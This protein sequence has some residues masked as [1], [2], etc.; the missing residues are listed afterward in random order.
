MR[1][2]HVVP[3]L[4][5]RFGG[6]PVAVLEAARALRDLGWDC[7]VVA[8]DLAEPASWSGRRVVDADLPEGAREVDVRLCPARWPYRLAYSPALTRALD[9][10]APSVDVVHIHMLFQY[11]QFAAFRAARRAGVPYVVTPHG[12]LDPH[13]RRRSR[14]L[15]ALTDLLW[16]RRML[17]GAAALHFTTA[18][19]A[20]LVSDLGFRAPTVVAPNG[21]RWASFQR[22]PSGR[23]F[24]EWYLGGHDGP[25]VM[26]LGRLSHKKGLDILVRA[27]AR[28]A[29]E[30][31]DAVLALVGPDDEGLTPRL[32][33]LAASEGVADRIVFVGMLAGEE[34]RAALAAADVWA[35]PSHTENFGLAVVE[36]MAAG[37]AVV[38][39]PAVNLASEISAAG[40]GLVRPQTPDAFA[41]AL[42]ELLADPGR[43]EALGRR[44]RAFARRYDWSAVAPAWAALYERALGLPELTR[45]GVE[46]DVRAG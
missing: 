18:D 27:F 1:A 40:A 28:A 33:S 12:A 9:E 13:L 30:R 37:K 45:A 15:K 22:L 4:S 14:L 10:L 39:S 25:V 32:R 31:S 44:A 2:L 16:Q 43:R 34:K 36:A 23:A 35:L 38:I 26:N 6:P 17:D 11:P 20:R 7:A 5:L 21:I 41:V 19:E 8:T 24:R 42:S 3:S 29:R 46:S